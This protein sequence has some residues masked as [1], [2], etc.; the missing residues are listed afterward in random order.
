MIVDIGRV[1]IKTMGHEADEK[2]VVV[3]AD[4]G[5]FV[6]IAGPRVKKRRCNIAHL[7]IL[8]HVITVKKGASE[9]EA[10]EALLKAGIV[11]KDDLAGKPNGYTPRPSAPAQQK[12]AE[13]KPEAKPAEKAGKK[14]AKPAK[15]EKL[16]AE[17]PSR[18]SLASL[19]K[20]PTTSKK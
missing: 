5:N 13:R 18:A 3:D 9:A 2:C 11:S 8:P 4:K 20:K 10:A 6:I 17:M 1:C 15:I 14:E 12:K 19:E 16:K 7:E